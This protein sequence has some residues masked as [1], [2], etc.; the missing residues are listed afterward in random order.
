MA[1][2]NSEIYLVQ[3]I[4]LDRNYVNVLS[5]SESQMLELCKQNQ[6]A[7]ANNYSF[8]RPQNS[9]YT[10]FRYEDC[11]KANYIAFQNPD[12][13]N[14]WFFAFIDEVIYKGES[15]TEITYKID[16]WSTWFDYWEKQPCFI[17]RQHVNNDTI[18]LH[19]VPENLDIGETKVEQVV[20]D[21]AI[22]DSFW[23]GVLSNYNPATKKDNGF[24]TVHN[25]QVFGSEIYV[26]RESDMVDLGLFIYN[27]ATDKGDTSA[28]SNIIIIPDFLID[29]TTLE[30]F[31]GEVG[32]QSYQFWKVPNNEEMPEKI[33]LDID[34]IT[35]Y[36]DYKPKNN[37]MFTYPYTYI[38]ATNNNGNDNIY[39]FEDF[40]NGKGTFFYE[41]VICVGCSGRLVPYNYKNVNQNISESIPLPKYPTCSWT[42]DAYVNW[43]T[44]QAV[45][46]PS[47]VALAGTDVA[48][49]DNAGSAGIS[50]ASNIASLIGSFYSASLLSNVAN[51]GNTGDINFSSNTNGFYLYQIRQKPEYLKIVDD[52]FSRF[53]YK[54][55]NI[56]TPNI[57]G[58]QNWNYIEIGQ[59]E[60]IGYGSTPTKFM[61]EINNACRKGVTIWHNHENLGNYNLSNKITN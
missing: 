32:G 4:K 8:I 3:N 61:E 51:G 7:H 55:N 37:K 1:I 10:N 47:Q 24:I 14:K 52:Y 45:N 27:T 34:L 29:Q 60:C 57:I 28:I 6:I 46:I 35:N 26:F 43:L 36:N 58:R 21:T 53:G 56:E 50:V 19:T 23:V 16:S 22:T 20:F 18:G 11:L 12:Y 17:S 59:N 15:N 41:G 2:L 44:Q 54:I 38:L 49:S 40:A 33:N 39:K 25:K 30:N 42:S 9:I 13:S 48:M 31:K 5:Y